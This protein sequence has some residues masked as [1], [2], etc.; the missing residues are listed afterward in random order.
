MKK[1]FTLIEV[2]IAMV[3]VAIAFTAILK[4]TENTVEATSHLQSHMSAHWV[5]TEILAAAQVG[6]MQLPASSQPLSGK[7]KLLGQLYFWTLTNKHTANKN[8]NLLTVTINQKQ[9]RLYTLSGPLLS[10]T[11]DATA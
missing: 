10:S 11:E 9:Q 4:A 2:M 3:V 8:I 1:G 7:T 6:S 5:A